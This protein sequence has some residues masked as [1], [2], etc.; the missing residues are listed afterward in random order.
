MGTYDFRSRVRT[1]SDKS[2]NVEISIK[3]IVQHILGVILWSAN[4]CWTRL[5]IIWGSITGQS[6]YPWTITRKSELLYESIS[7]SI[8]FTLCKLPVSTFFI[9]DIAFPSFHKRTCMAYSG[10]K[11]ANSTAPSTNIEVS[12]KQNINNLTESIPRR[13]NKCKAIKGAINIAVATP[14]SVFQYWLLYPY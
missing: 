11:I 14:N 9:G 10:K 1:R 13:L 7:K 5:V 12:K 8:F 4:A 3:W 2:W 6:Y